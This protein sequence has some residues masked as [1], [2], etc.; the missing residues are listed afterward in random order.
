MNQ[1]CDPH[2]L[3]V[4]KTKSV[5]P[6]TKSSSLK[7]ILIIQICLNGPL[8]TYYTLIY[9]KL[10]LVYFHSTIFFSLKS[11]CSIP[12]AI[13]LSP[14]VYLFHSSRSFPTF[15]ILKCRKAVNLPLPTNPHPPPLDPLQAWAPTET[16]L[17]L[18]SPSS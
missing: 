1:V 2:N 16:G 12:G 17:T 15:K 9:F 3:A 10:L 18:P 8:T 7:H 5:S 6:K 11:Y 13:L 4:T 14:K